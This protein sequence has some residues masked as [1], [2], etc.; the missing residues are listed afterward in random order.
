MEKLKGRGAQ[1]LAIN[2][3]ESADK[4]FEFL[5]SYPVSF[6]LLLHMHGRVIKQYPVIGLPTTY[7]VDPKGKVIRRAV[8]NRDWDDPALYNQSLK[9]R[10]D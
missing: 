8:G 3:G 9:L 7:I 6:P 4:V 1:L 5:A 10:K 2:V